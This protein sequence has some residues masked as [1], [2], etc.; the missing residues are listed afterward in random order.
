MIH[1]A[2]EDFLRQV[3]RLATAVDPLQE[4]R[5]ERPPKRAIQLER[6][7]GACGD[8]APL[9]RS[10]MRTF[11]HPTGEYAR[12]NRFGKGVRSDRTASSFT[13]SARVH[14]GTGEGDR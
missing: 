11:T 8:L 3:L 6:G 12:G 2:H 5:D 9:F 4:V 13:T 10:V 14:R 1:Q 7:G